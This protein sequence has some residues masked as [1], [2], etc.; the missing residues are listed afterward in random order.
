MIVITTTFEFVNDL[1]SYARLMIIESRSYE[2]QL[3]FSEMINEEII[4]LA[5]RQ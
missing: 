2:S 4:I 1:R 3:T 5:R